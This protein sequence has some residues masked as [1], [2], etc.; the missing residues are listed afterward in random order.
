MSRIALPLL[1][2]EP[3]AQ[4]PPPELV[5]LLGQAL[6]FF[7]RLGRPSGADASRVKGGVHGL[8]GLCSAGDVQAPILSWRQQVGGFLD[9]HCY[10]SNPGNDT[11]SGV[12][13]RSQPI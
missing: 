6:Q 8:Q 4:A 10:M 5:A 2:I 7:G 13:L 9:G 1:C 12:S 3:P 11:P